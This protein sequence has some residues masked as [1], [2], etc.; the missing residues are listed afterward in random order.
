[1]EKSRFV[2]RAFPWEGKE[3]IRASVGRWKDATTDLPPHSQSLLPS[4]CHRPV[5]NAASHVQTSAWD[6]TPPRVCV[7]ICFVLTCLSCQLAFS[8]ATQLRIKWYIYNHLLACY[9]LSPPLSRQNCRPTYSATSIFCCL[10]SNITLLSRLPAWTANSFICV[11]HFLSELEKNQQTLFFVFG[12]VFFFSLM[13]KW[14]TPYDIQP[15]FPDRIK[16]IGKLATGN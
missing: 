14:I 8:R 13:V 4:V 9:L 1:M 15:Q 16:T 2:Y 7:K 11:Q 5:F 3:A 10:A 12:F 6:P